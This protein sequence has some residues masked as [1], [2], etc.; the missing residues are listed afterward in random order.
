MSISCYHSLSLQ[1]FDSD[2][3]GLVLEADLS[4]HIPINSLRDDLHSNHQEQ[5]QQHR[6][7]Q[8]GDVDA[9]G[10]AHHDELATIP[11]KMNLGK[12][13]RPK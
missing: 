12:Y 9:S 6:S 3:D 7:K 11:E 13:H 2:G 5:K 8:R 1:F 4:G 10:E